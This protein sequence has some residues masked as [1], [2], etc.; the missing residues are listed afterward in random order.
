MAEIASQ[1]V[2]P[3]QMSALLVGQL[4]RPL[5][6]LRDQAGGRH[7]RTSFVHVI[8]HHP[9]TRSHG[10]SLST[11]RPDM[12]VFMHPPRLSLTDYSSEK[13]LE[14]GAQVNNKKTRCFTAR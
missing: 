8:G 2:Q 13:V 14:L 11:I 10:Q 12:L 3:E 4:A 5:R 6:E 9:R 7:K 1:W